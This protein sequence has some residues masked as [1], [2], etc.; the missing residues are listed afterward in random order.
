MFDSISEEVYLYVAVLSICVAVLLGVIVWSVRRHLDP[1]LDIECDSPIEDL[2]PSLAGLTL[3]SAIAGNSV[4]VFENG[5]YFDE[6]LRRIPTAKH[7]VPFRD[8]PLAGRRARQAGG[9]RAVRTRSRRQA[10]TRA[11]RRRRLEE[12]REGRLCNR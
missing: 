11:A 6:L 8:V 10:G 1:E 7:S 9:R 5:A 2:I 12:D 3:S 4:E